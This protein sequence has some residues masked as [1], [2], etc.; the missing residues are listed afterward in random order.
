MFLPSSPCVIVMVGFEDD[1][2]NALYPKGFLDDAL[3]IR[4]P[5]HRQ[6]LGKEFQTIV[7]DANIAGILENDVVRRVI[8]SPRGLN[9]HVIIRV[10]ALDVLSQLILSNAYH[11]VYAPHVNKL[12]QCAL[13][14]NMDTNAYTLL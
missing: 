1:K 6:R 4:D 3:F 13:W 9:K 8:F 11:I 5:E 10:D 7:V 12:W 2:L 14:L